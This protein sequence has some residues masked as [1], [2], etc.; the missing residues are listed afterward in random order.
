MVRWPLH[1]SRPVRRVYVSGVVLCREQP[2]RKC[3]FLLLISLSR[4]PA[5]MRKIC[6]RAF[7]PRGTF[8]ALVLITYNTLLLTCLTVVEMVGAAR[9]WRR[10][11]EDRLPVVGSFTR[12]YT[13][14][15]K[16]R[17]SH[18]RGLVRVRRG[19]AKCRWNSRMDC[20]L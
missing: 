5:P 15:A 16:G 19:G 12:P 18:V 9:H 14:R 13:L 8:N 11:T 2:Q 17:N 4:E 6:R 20:L 1:H 10:T 7:C 3:F